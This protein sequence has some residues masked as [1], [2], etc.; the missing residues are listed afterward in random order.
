MTNN[1]D[2]LLRRE[3]GVRQ[4]AASIFNYTIGSGIFVMPALVAAQL[5]PAGILAYLVCGVVMALVATCF[6]EAGSRV[7]VSGGPYAYVEA[8]MGPLPGFVAGALNVT[9]DIVTAAALATIFAGSVAALTGAASAVVKVVLILSVFATVAAINVRG[10][11][12]GARLIETLL[13]AKLVPLVVFV[14]AGAVFVRPASLAWTFT[15]SARSVLGTAGILIFAYTG[16]EGALQ[17]S[18]EVRAPARTVP[19]AAFVAIGG[20]TAFYVAIHLV[21]QGILGPALA[22]SQAAPLADAAAAFSGP[23]GRNVMLAT[24]ILSIFATLSGQVL[25]GPRTLFAFGRDGLAPRSLAFVHASFRTP[26][27]AIVTFAAIAAALAISGTFEQLAI[28]SNV[29][30]LSVYALSAI[31]AWML[32]RRDVRTNGDPFVAPG[33]PLVPL[34]ACT[35]IGW[36]LVE[37]ATRIEWAALAIVVI[38]SLAIYAL[39]ARRAHMSTQSRERSTAFRHPR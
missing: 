26:H 25:A 36:M 39:R 6:A 3:L 38:I 30:A 22:G 32:R 33:G 14:V 10:V 29:G 21:A 12:K 9:A 34:L 7:A 17:P 4:L 35:A 23:A 24:V 37:T 18:G 1:P 16:I 27:V 15:P 13:T 28:L 5:G 31:S 11:S 8:A 19:R 2:D 20:I